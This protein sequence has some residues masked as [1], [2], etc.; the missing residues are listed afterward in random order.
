MDLVQDDEKVQLMAHH[1][2]MELS[3]DDFD[4]HH[5]FLRSGDYV[6]AVGFPSTTNV[7][8]LTLKLNCPIELV[9]PCLNL[10][11]IPEKLSD[12]RLINKNRVLDYIVSPELREHMVI[13]SLV[14]QAIPSA[15]IF[16]SANSAFGWK[17][18]GCKRPTIQ[19][20]TES[21]WAAGRGVSFT[22]GCSGALVEKARY[23]GL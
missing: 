21:P 22:S 12:R 15:T 8:E 20:C 2:L 17:R 6:V 19:N 9:S 10:T 13:R 5:S 14:I 11:T 1:K 18:Y 3:V 16:G 4:Q 23:F 7:G